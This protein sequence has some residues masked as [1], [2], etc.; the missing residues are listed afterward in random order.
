MML[1]FLDT[2]FTGL[3][4]RW[5]RLISIGLVSEGGREFYAELMPEGYM[6]K[7]TPW[8]QENVL[9]L[10]QGRECLMH[11]HDLPKRLAEWISEMG[12]VQIVTDSPESD[13]KFLEAMLAPWPQNL[14]RRPVWF[15][16]H[17]LGAQHQEMLEASWNDCFTPDKPQ[18]HALNDARALRETW[19]LA[20]ALE[21]FKAFA[22]RLG[23]Q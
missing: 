18:H 11:P 2:E 14:N 4:Q 6:E 21:D 1:L 3:G 10:L 17:A 7:V 8:V 23:L 12:P 22:E 16:V 9:P 15:D 13:F 20:R 5:P 19:Q